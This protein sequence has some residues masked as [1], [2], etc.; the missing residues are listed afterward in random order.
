VTPSFGLLILIGTSNDLRQLVN[1]CPLFVNRKLGVTDDVDKQDVRDLKLDL[2]L[3]LS[4][5]IGNLNSMTNSR[6]NAPTGNELHFAFPDKKTLSLQTHT[7]AANSQILR[8]QM[9]PW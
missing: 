7:E 9:R 2:F 3:N 4:G 1:R 6:G 5:H 8:Q